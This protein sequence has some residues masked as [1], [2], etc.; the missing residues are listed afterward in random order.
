MPADTHGV[1]MADIDISSRQEGDIFMQA[2]Q[3]S[4]DH[5][6]ISEENS[7]EKQIMQ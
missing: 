1:D 6:T 3:E 2:F 4:K 7:K 5:D